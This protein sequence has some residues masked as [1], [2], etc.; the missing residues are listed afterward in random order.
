MFRNINFLRSIKEKARSRKLF[1]NV[2]YFRSKQI[3]LM[4]V[5]EGEET[6]LNEILSHRN[7]FFPTP[8]QLRGLPKNFWRP[9]VKARRVQ[10]ENLGTM[11]T[12]CRNK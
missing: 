4:L 5:C 11:H 3:P 2:T 10:K 7:W 8:E 6:F 1:K 9:Q 12:P